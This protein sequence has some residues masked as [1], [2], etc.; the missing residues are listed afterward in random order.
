MRTV[1]TANQQWGY[2]L[3]RMYLYIQ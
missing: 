2:W 3:H 1:V